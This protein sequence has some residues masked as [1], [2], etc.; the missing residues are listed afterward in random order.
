MNRLTKLG[1]VAAIG[2]LLTWP[3]V[4]DV[5]DSVFF[6]SPDGTVAFDVRDVS[7]GEVLS[8]LVSG[9]AIELDWVD[10]AYANERISG[11]FNGSAEAVLQRLL[12]QTDFVAVYDREGGGTRLA[13]L[14]IVG[15]ASSSSKVVGLQVTNP[16]APAPKPGAITITPPTPAD[17]ATPL[18]IAVSKGTI[19]PPLLAPLAAAKSLPLLIPPSPADREVPLI[20]PSETR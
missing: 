8:R 1:V 16:P 3:G 13:R 15:K 2:C 9:K 20:A 17:L 14:I 19:A 18:Y 11:V 6:V 12:A 10:A 4:A 7:R 5:G